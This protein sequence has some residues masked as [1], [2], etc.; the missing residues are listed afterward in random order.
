GLLTGPLR[1]GQGRNR[2]RLLP[3]AF[4]LASARPGRQCPRNTMDPG[5]GTTP[6]E[7]WPPWLLD[8]LRSGQEKAWTVAFQRLWPIALKAG[9]HPELRLTRHEAEEVASATL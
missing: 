2:L 1:A 8:E 3:P 6:P 9:L 7:P 4:E 5:P